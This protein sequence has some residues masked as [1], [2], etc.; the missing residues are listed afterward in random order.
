MPIIAL[1]REMGSR[2]KDVAAAL[3]E[4]L[5]VPVICH[6]VIDHLADRMRLRRS[7]V[8]RLLEGG[9]SLVERMT[10]DRTSLFLHCAD[11]IVAACLKGGGAIVRGCGDHLLRDIS[12][13]VTARVCAPREL[14]V[15][16]MTERPDT[17]DAELVAEEVHRSDEAHAAIV[18]RNLG[19]H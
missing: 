6:E 11:Q 8:T 2:G 14:R 13:V 9:T 17:S 4:A 5:G 15:Q 7:H 1:T 16:R 3:G 18:R 12:H 10:T 19:V